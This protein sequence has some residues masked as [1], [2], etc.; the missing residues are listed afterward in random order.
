MITFLSKE[1]KSQAGVFINLGLTAGVATSVNI[2]MPLNSIDWLNKHFYKNNPTTTPL[3]THSGL[4]RTMAFVAFVFVSYL[5]FSVPEKKLVGSKPSLKEVIGAFPKIYKN[6]S[7]RTFVLLLFGFKMFPA[8]VAESVMLKYYQNGMERTALV[9]QDTILMPISFAV[10]IFSGWFIRKLKIKKLITGSFF[11]SSWGLLLLISKF[12]ILISFVNDV[13]DRGY[14][15]DIN[16]RIPCK[17]LPHSPILTL[18]REK[19]LWHG[20]CGSYQLC[21]VEVT[22]L[23]QHPWFV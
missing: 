20:T 2:F 10:M 13:R 15:V 17:L 7:L 1:W 4:L 22:S 6:I 3:I 23:C 21:L 18:S 16:S 9:N 11:F 5:F 14:N 12:I 19:K 8:L